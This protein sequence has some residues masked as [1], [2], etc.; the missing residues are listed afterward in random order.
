MPPYVEGFMRYLLQPRQNSLSMMKSTSYWKA[1][2]SA[3]LC[4]R[5]VLEGVLK[6][7]RAW[8]AWLGFKFE[9]W[10]IC[11]KVT[12]HSC[13]FFNFTI[14]FESTCYNQKRNY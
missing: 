12:S 11:K 6:S 10:A 2:A 5:Q 8:W 3:V 13:G 1:V 7:N 4:W 9:L 14:D